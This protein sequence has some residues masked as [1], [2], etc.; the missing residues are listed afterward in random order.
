MLAFALSLAACAVSAELPSIRATDSHF[1]ETD[2]N[3]PRVWVS[4][5]N[6]ATRPRGRS[7]P[8]GTAVFGNRPAGRDERTT[9][10]GSRHSESARPERLVG[11]SSTPSSAG[12]DLIRIGAD[13][14]RHGS[15]GILHPLQSECVGLPA[16]AM[17]KPDLALG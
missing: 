13:A 9:P 4:R 14:R 15:G 2:S 3:P 12:A 10:R 5:M 11:R 17:L 8:R 7:V 6:F 16:G 1:A